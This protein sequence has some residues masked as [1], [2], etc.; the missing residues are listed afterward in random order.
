M[1]V[2]LGDGRI[3]PAAG[4]IT[5]VEH[6]ADVQANDSFLDGFLW[7]EGVAQVDVRSAVARQR[8]VG[9]LGVVE[10]RLTNP[11]RMTD[12]EKASVELS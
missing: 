11:L 9:I 2:A 4:G 3:D 1:A 6:I 7:F 5:A 10:C 12:G 8:A